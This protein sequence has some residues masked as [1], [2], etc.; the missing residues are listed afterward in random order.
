MLTIGNNSK[1]DMLDRYEEGKG[2]EEVKI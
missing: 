1:Q 2:S